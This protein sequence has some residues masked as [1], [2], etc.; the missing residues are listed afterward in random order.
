MSEHFFRKIGVKKAANDKKYHTVN[1]PISIGFEPR[2][3]V[4]II[5]AT[6]DGRKAAIVVEVDTRPCGIVSQLR[7]TTNDNMLK[8]E[9]GYS[10]DMRHTATPDSVLYTVSELN[11]GATFSQISP[12]KQAS[13]GSSGHTTKPQSHTVLSSFIRFIL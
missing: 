3:H 8:V 2:T 10:E 1:L 5:P 7:N 12:I 6:Y 13:L 9:D 4:E 11:T